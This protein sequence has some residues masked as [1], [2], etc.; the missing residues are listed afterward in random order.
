MFQVQCFGGY[1]LCF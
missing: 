1:R